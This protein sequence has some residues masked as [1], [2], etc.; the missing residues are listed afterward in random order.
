[1]GPDPRDGPEERIGR[2]PLGHG[3]AG[4]LN[5]GDPGLDRGDLRPEIGTGGGQAQREPPLRDR[6]PPGAA[7]S[8]AWRTGG[9]S[10][11]RRGGSGS[12]IGA[13]AGRSVVRQRA[14]QRRQLGTGPAETLH[15]VPQ[16][17]EGA[18]GL[19]VEEHLALL[20]KVGAVRR[21]LPVVFVPGAVLGAPVPVGDAAGEEHD[22]RALRLQERG[23]RLVV[24]P[25][26]LQPAD[27]LPAPGRPLRLLDPRPEL[28]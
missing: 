26:G 21:V 8:Q 5:R 20:Q 27:H 11:Q 22:V 10:A 24:G 15:Q 9:S 19:A 7:G 25:R 28:R 12:P 17:R 13:R 16:L 2:E 4:R 1:M 23:H 6:R 14:L 18:G 3:R